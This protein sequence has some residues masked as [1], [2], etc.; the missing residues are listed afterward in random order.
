ML[1]LAMR[2]QRQL[3]LRLVVLLKS[4]AERLQ[5]THEELLQR[6]VSTARSM[7]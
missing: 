2:R 7:N 3:R 4:Q 1:R 6:E 5:G